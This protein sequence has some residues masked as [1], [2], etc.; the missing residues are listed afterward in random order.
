MTRK[1][2][3]PL[4]N[5]ADELIG[6]SETIGQKTQKMQ[7]NRLDLQLRTQELAKGI[8]VSMELNGLAPTAARI[9]QSFKA[10]RDEAGAFDQLCRESDADPLEYDQALESLRGSAHDVANLCRGIHE[11]LA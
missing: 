4:P 11:E 1:Q 3:W 8:I 6:W 5:L 10:L 2:T 7:T 9:E